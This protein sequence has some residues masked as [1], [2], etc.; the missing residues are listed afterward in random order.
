MFTSFSMYPNLL[1]C[2]KPEDHD[3][4]KL[5]KILAKHPEVC[6]V[7]LIAVDIAGNDTDVKIPISQFIE[8]MSSY[9]HGSV[10]TDGSSVVLPGIANINDAQ[11]D[12]IA[13]LDVNWY[14]DY[15]YEHILPDIK[16]PCGTLRIPCFLRHN[17][18]F[19]CSRSLL[20]RAIAS[21]AHRIK[22][23]LQSYPELCPCSQDVSQLTDVKL[24][25]ATELEFWVKTPDDVV[26]EEH[27]SIS[28]GLKEQYWKRTKGVVRS[29]LERSLLVLD[30]Y[31]FNPE[32]G[33]KE[34]GGVKAHL[35]GTG[36]MD[37]I[38]EQ[39]EVDWSYDYDLQGV[40]NEQAI[41]IIIEEIF[42]LHGLEISY[43]AKPISGV[44]GSGEHTHFNVWLYFKNGERCNLF[45]PED[46]TKDNLSCAG[47]GALMGILK[48][49][50][51]LVAPFVSC[52]ND[53]FNRLKP[54]FE[55]PTHPVAAISEKAGEL[56]RNRTVLISL[57]RNPKAPKPSTRFEMR[58]PAPG[59]NLYFALAAICQVMFDGIKAVATSGRS[60][61][62][63]SQELVAELRKKQGEETP[64]L[65]K[66]YQYCSDLDIFSAYSDAERDSLFGVPAANVHD[67]LQNLVSSTE[68][69]AILTADN[70][71]TERLLQSYIQAMLDLWVRELKDRLIEVNRNKVRATKRLHSLDRQS[72]SYLLERDLDSL[73]FLDE[74]WYEIASIR[75]EL[76]QSSHDES[77]TF[78]TSLFSQ[79]YEALT[80]GN[81]AEASALQ[82]EMDTKME[83]LNKL[84]QVYKENI[85]D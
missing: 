4:S 47:Y 23:L 32:M 20:K 6:F 74:L 71:F 16:L 83:K 30:K 22:E 26:A 46:I 42:R 64:Y 48:H 24:T 77:N 50:R 63:C 17:Q 27:L 11:V 10:Q 14:V 36:D 34:V 79:I 70:V 38:L 21:F 7:S 84:Y 44:A 43:L 18:D 31:G 76:V 35:T 85:L 62:S 8:S 65:K 53:T 41:R 60:N 68:Q 49:Y 66:E 54:G 12:L 40:D 19:V 25:I 9:L 45:A 5:A 56:S 51:E 82:L 75:S 57:I 1:Y 81:L 55:A 61:P 59:T 78:T 80:N 28:Q 15:N 37:H 67:T 39:L 29:A 72:L 2:V 52:T 73:K 69:L 13:D 3:E 33:H 58:S